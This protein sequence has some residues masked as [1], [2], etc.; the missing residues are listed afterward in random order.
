MTAADI[1]PRI[2]PRNIKVSD[3]YSSNLYLY[4]RQRK[5]IT[6]LRHKPT[7]DYYFTYSNWRDDEWKHICGARLANVLTGRKTDC[8]DPYM[9][10]YLGVFYADCEEVTDQFWRD[11]I[12]SGRCAFDRNHDRWWL[13]DENRFTDVGTMKRCNWCGQ[14]FTK[15]VEKVVK[16]ERRTVWSPVKRCRP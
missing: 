11:Y 16:I 12:R 10:V 9:A 2:K 13:G 3:K 5:R 7:G 14:W 4:V 15:H 6:M 1:L 8:S